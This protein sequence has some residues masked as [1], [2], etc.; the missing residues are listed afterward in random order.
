MFKTPLVSVSCPVPTTYETISSSIS[1]SPLSVAIPENVAKGVVLPSETVV[2]SAV[3][4]EVE[5]TITVSGLI[6]SI[7][8]LLFAP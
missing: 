8:I 5:G 3:S 6:F 1:A 4:D 7:Y 2:L